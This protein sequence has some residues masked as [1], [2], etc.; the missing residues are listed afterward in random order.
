MLQY[1]NT[2][3]DWLCTLF[4]FLFLSYGFKKMTRAYF[5]QYYDVIV[6][7]TFDHLKG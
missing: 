4:K 3:N 5:P 7:L 6:K 1:W 2:T